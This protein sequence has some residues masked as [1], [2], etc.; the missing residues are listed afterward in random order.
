[1]ALTMERLNSSAKSN[2]SAEKYETHFTNAIALH[3]Q[4]A[5]NVTL[6]KAKAFIA[7]VLLNI[8]S[9]K[10]LAGLWCIKKC[11]KY[12]IFLALHFTFI[13]GLQSCYTKMQSVQS[14]PHGLFGARL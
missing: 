9:K 8:F 12:C 4:H 6:C 1:M 10:H 13:S 5:E 7:L 3:W 14:K 2:H 11:N